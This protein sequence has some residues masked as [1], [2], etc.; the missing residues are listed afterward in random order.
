VPIAARRREPEERYI[1]Q[2]IRCLLEHP[3]LAARVPSAEI[4]TLVAAGPLR[5]LLETLV[6]VGGQGP[7]IDLEALCERLEP[8]TR[9]RLRALAAGD[10]AP[11]EATAARTVADTLVA[12]RKRSLRMQRQALKTRLREPDA[13]AAAL[14][15][16]IQRLR[17]EPVG[18]K[19]PRL[20]T[21]HG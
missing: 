7:R 21:R 9:S 11:S 6:A 14:L 15:G 10:D 2:L 19:P 18:T 8:P 17:E 1:E 3:A 5:E 12:L 13:D 4:E 16:E 20:V